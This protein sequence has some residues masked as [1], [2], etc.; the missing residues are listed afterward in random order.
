VSPIMF[1][2][3]PSIP[4]WFVRFALNGFSHSVAAP[5]VR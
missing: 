5:R 1:S 2:Q 3:N 4:K